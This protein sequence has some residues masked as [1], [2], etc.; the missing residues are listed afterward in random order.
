MVNIF[1][2]AKDAEGWTWYMI[3]PHQW[4]KQTFVARVQPAARPENVTGRW[5][6]VDLYEQTLIA[7]DDDKPVF[8]TLIASGLDNFDT[9]EGLFTIWARLSTD[10]MSGA[11]GAP[12]AYDLQSVPWVMYFNGSM[13][14]HGTYWHD[15]F[16]YR[17]SHGCVNMSISDARWLYDWTAAS[18]PN[19]DG[20]IVNYVYVFSSGK[21]GVPSGST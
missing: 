1:A 9:A 7:Y 14:L 19:A 13:S 4:L 11:T 21:Y 8:A 15:L 6:A 18:T 20:S 2:E 16:G 17:H 3:G 10:G 5:I 12:S